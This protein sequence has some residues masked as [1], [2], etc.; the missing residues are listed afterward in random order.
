MTSSGYWVFL[1]PLRKGYHDLSIEGS[2]QYGR[3][4]SG[5]TYDIT[6]K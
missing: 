1:R 2:Y 3:L 6:V 4:H 5:A